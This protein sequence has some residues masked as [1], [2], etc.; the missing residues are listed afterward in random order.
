MRPLV[1]RRSRGGCPQTWVL[2]RHRNCPSASCQWTTLSIPACVGILRWSTAAPAVAVTGA[3]GPETDC[4]RNRA[5]GGGRLCRHA[6]VNSP[7]RSRICFRRGGRCRGASESGR[8]TGVPCCRHRERIAQDEQRF[9]HGPVAR[10]RAQYAA[11]V[12]RGQTASQ[13][14]GRGGDRAP[15]LDWR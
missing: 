10:R 1:Q 4:K 3:K 11:D 8:S 14:P 2:Q 13:R 12:A 9:R 6:P 7:E 5:E 15:P